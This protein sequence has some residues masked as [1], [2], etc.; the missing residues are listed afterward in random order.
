MLHCRT[1][2]FSDGCN[3]IWEA[4]LIIVW[5]ASNRTYQ[6]QTLM[7]WENLTGK[8]V[9]TLILYQVLWHSPLI[10]VMIYE[11]HFKG[12]QGVPVKGRARKFLWWPIPERVAT[13]RTLQISIPHAVERIEPRSDGAR[14]QTWGVPWP[15]KFWPKLGGFL[16]IPGF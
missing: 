7:R 13:N 3:K 10:K 2:N 4:A 14:R 15:G 9:R 12:K 1:N 11:Y 5:A 16:S 8:E 6:G